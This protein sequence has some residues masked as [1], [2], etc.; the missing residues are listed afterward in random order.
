MDME[1]S[2]HGEPFTKTLPLRIP[3][4][5]SSSDPWAME[6]GNSTY[7]FLVDGGS[8]AYDRQNDRSI[9]IQSHYHLK[10]S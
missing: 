2:A 5:S 10:R 1:W 7:R 8:A 3:R 4:M 6:G 9:T